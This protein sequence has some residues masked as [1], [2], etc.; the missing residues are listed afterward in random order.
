MEF[1]KTRVCQLSVV[2]SMTDLIHV[3]STYAIMLTVFR[4]VKNTL[5]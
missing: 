4:N 5:F 3:A 2:L 1:T